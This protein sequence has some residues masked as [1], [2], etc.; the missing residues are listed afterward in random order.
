[1]TTLGGGSVAAYGL[2]YQYLSTVEYFLRYLREHPELIA[3]TTLVVEPLFKNAND[4][5]DDIVDFAIE[6][7]DAAVH[8]I[9][10]KATTKSDQ[11]S[12]QP[13][14]ARAALKRLL[15]HP[16]DN[17]TLLTNKPLS[18]GLSSECAITDDDSPVTTYTWAEGPQRPPGADPRRVF[19]AVDHR[20]PAEL[21]GSIAELVRHFRKIG[22]LKQGLTSARLLVGILL[23]FIFDAAAGLEP[24]RITALDL[25][26]KVH[27]PDPR[28][29]QLAGGFDWG[30]PMS[31]IP[32]YG[33]TVARMEILDEIVEQLAT[34]DIREVPKLVVLAGHTGIGKSVIATDYSHADRVSYQFVCWIDCRDPEMI[35]PRIRDIVAQL[36]KD[37]VPPAAEVSRIFTGILGR[38]AGPWLL[39]FDGIQ[40]ASDIESYVP[41]VGCGSILIT[42]N[43]SL[44]WWDTAH[45]VQIGTFTDDEAIECFTSYAAISSEALDEVRQPIREIVERLGR[46]P[47]AVSMAGLYFRNTQGRLDELALQYFAD[48]AALD[49]SFSVPRGFGNKTAFDAIR[50]AVENLG[51]GTRAP[52]RRD[53]QKLL[54]AGSLLAPE[55]LPVNLLL[56]ATAEALHISITNL[57]KPAEVE[58]ELRRDVIATL[59]TQTIA[60]RVTNAEPGAIT[61]ASDTVAVHPL[62]HNVLQR[63]CL[64]RVR[65]GD[66][67]QMAASLMYFLVGWIGELRTAGQFFAV[68]QLR[69]H[70]QALLELVNEREPLSTPSADHDKHYRYLKAML[71][72]ELGTCQFS[73]G[74]LQ[75]AYNL[76]LAA[77]QALSVIP[78]DQNARVIAMKCIF[79]QIH[80]LSM[81][82][83]PPPLLAIHA[84]LLVQFCNECESNPAEA[85]RDTAYRFAGEVLAMVTRTATYRGS[86]PLRAIADQ[87]NQIAARDPSPE[88]RPHTR[89]AIRNQMIDAGEYQ[90]ILDN[91]PEW[92]TADQGIHNAVIFDGLE[93]VANLYLGRIA[94]AAALI[95]TILE[96]KPYGQHLLIFTHEALKKV[97]KGLDQ[98]IPTA[99]PDE[100]RLQ[101]MLGDVLARYNELGGPPNGASNST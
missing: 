27:M 74:N 60:H 63:I 80:D 94:D 41:S 61:P 55:L 73:R 26:A 78:K 86:E 34:D 90:A 32:N 18:P 35:A 89:N 66:L 5:D 59:R 31:G 11:Y 37:V 19:L 47:L 3:R 58:A 50:Y 9:Q 21:R 45:Q 8:H 33:S 16:A 84:H 88:T 79:D 82:E 69:M 99:G 72:S 81:G 44:G 22:R 28:M 15:D 67:Q 23:D 13:A 97:A 100:A 39:V 70:A 68:E 83:A 98:V 56:P 54:Y 30:L 95:G 76:G 87:L 92:R 91:L 38:V 10:V 64:A 36:T 42:T 65:P 93:A 14:D 53:T 40:N 29:A 20:T 52:R 2:R 62:V 17:S 4:A 6:L 24:A 77:V 1:M 51:K 71:Q 7:D 46:I 75:E 12:L 25:L 48:L 85:F 43:N 101:Q 57:P 96:L 49:D